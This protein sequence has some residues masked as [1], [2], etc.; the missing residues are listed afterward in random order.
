MDGVVGADQEVGADAR[1]L[2]R[3]GEHQLANARPVAAVDA[4]HVIR[5][6]VRVHRDFRVGVRAEQRR[7]LRADGPIA[8]RRAFG[9]AGHDADVVGHD[10]DVDGQSLTAEKALHA[11]LVI[12]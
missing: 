9:G 3:R 10:A 4:L 2:V 7:A 8:E 12:S 11:F 5:E 1:E 6:R